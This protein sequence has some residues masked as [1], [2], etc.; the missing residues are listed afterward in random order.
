MTKTSARGLLAATAMTL[1]LGSAAGAQTREADRIA[2]LEGQVRD[3]QAVVYAVE[4][5]GAPIR[6]GSQA[7]AEPAAPQ[8]V[9]AYG[10]SDVLKMAELE[11]EIARLTGRIEELTFRMA[12]QQ[13]QLDTIMAVLGDTRGGGARMSVD[14]APVYQAPVDQAFVDGGAPDG[15]VVPADGTAAGAADAA[16]GAPADLSG[17][18][19]ARETVA[20]DL[21]DTEDDAYDLAYEALLAGDYARSEAAFEAYVDQFPDGVRT[22]EAKYLLGEIYLATGAY[23]E[24]ATVFL[25]HVK[26]YPGDVRAPEA[27][28]KLGTAFARLEKPEE[29]CKVFRVGQS[30]FPDMSA[31]VRARFAAEQRGAGCA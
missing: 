13:R 24:A 9:Q 4:R 3:L 15:A 23:A 22:A 8:G 26:S 17:A 28:L 31:N 20:V 27:Y 11:Q 21:P 2:R 7:R 14:Q 25:D 1:T 6:Q 5:Q 29:A 12:N 16:P 10:S 19:P 30:K 18:L